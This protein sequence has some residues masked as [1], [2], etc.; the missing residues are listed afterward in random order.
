MGSAL[1]ASLSRGAAVGFSAL[2]AGYAR[3]RSAMGTA[4][5]VGGIGAVLGLGAMANEAIQARTNFASLSF[6]L[7][8]GRGVLISW[9]DLQARAQASS[10]QWAKNN[11]ELA[12]TMKDVFDTSGDINFSLDTME[13]IAMASRATG[14]EMRKVGGLVGALNQ[15][16]GL[17]AD[18]AGNA[19]GAIFELGNQGGLSFEEIS[20]SLSKLGSVAKQAGLEGREGLQELVGL[21]NEM[22]AAAGSG[23]GAVESMSMILG[24][25]AG[26]VNV[27]KNLD[28]QLGIDVEGKSPIQ[29]FREM[30]IKTNAEADELGK[31]FTEKGRI[32][33]A[34]FKGKDFDEIVRRARE[35]STDEATLREKAAQRMAEPA[36]KFEAAIEKVRQ[37][38]TSPE[39]I[40]AIEK[41]ADVLPKVADLF[42]DLV[43]FVGNNPFTAGSL[44]LGGRSLG[45]FGMLAG[46]A[47]QMGSA[48][49][50]MTAAANTMSTA[51]GTMQGG[52][53]AWAS[54]ARNPSNLGPAAAA[55]TIGVAAAVDQVSALAREMAI[56]DRV[57]KQYGSI[58]DQQ[59]GVKRTV[60]DN[61]ARTGSL[62]IWEGP[63]GQSVLFQND[64]GSFGA[65]SQD[66]E[67]G[68]RNLVNPSLARRKQELDT[69]AEG[70][71][72]A[73][74]GPA[75]FAATLGGGRNNPFFNRASQRVLENGA[76]SVRPSEMNSA[77]T[78]GSSQKPVAKMDPEQAALLQQ[79]LQAQRS[80]PDKT[81]DVRISNVD[82]LRAATGG[83]RPAHE[84][85]G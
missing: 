4:L 13:K 83:V 12:A 79:M 77:S 25:L 20:A 35:S 66:D 18:E 74:L 50:T 44:V 28:K 38:L 17:T 49:G 15:Q 9:Q 10:G 14:V 60:F 34:A 68:M 57:D 47:G 33:S 26:D 1:G 54:I 37:K 58:E 70:K 62:P 63:G 29:L 30:V 3:V 65:I 45:G 48:A 69:E 52:M 22:V 78:G 16:F 56:R 71:R 24:R 84:G 73:E 31:V 39:V 75:A 82:E 53:S 64:D 5:Q 51:A 2:R 55:A 19:I 36:A 40:G 7:E 46:P 61:A 67:V 43:D 11:T 59:E 42:T 8:R 72:V 6:A 23:Q 32:I 76:S 41:L 81:L 80:G 85:S 27:R 21:A